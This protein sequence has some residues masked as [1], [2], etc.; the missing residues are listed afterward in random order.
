M[1]ALHF[2]MHV[3]EWDLHHAVTALE[4]R[5]VLAFFSFEELLLATQSNLNFLLRLVN[6]IFRCLAKLSAHFE[7][8]LEKLVFDDG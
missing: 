2:M 7:E 6:Q 8:L 4:L 5:V 1:A 3:V